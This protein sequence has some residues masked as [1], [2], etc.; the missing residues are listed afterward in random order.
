MPGI[1]EYAPVCGRYKISPDLYAFGP[2]NMF[3]FYYSDI[4]KS[5]N[6]F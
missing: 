3:N 2:Q 6:K 1:C 5:R 4:F